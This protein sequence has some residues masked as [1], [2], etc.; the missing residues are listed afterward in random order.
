M[1][2]P[3]L[4]SFARKQAVYARYYEGLARRAYAAAQ[5]EADG[6]IQAT[7]LAPTNPPVSDQRL[8]PASSK[9]RIAVRV[10]TPSA[11]RNAS[12]IV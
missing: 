3:N 1:F 5:P 8:V 9:S 12:M 4:C 11:D 2:P 7:L 6:R 10:R